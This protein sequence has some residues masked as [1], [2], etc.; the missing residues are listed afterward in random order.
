MELKEIKRSE[1]S[2]IAD[3]FLF[4]DVDSEFVKETLKDDRCRFL[5][6]KKGIE[7]FSVVDYRNHLGIVLSGSI[8]V[9]KPA[10]SRYI[11]SVL[12][13]GSIFGAANLF[14]RESECVTVLTSSATCRIVLLSQKLLED[15]MRHDFEIAQNLIRFLSGRVQFLNDKIQGLVAST[16][17][18]ALAH[19][20]MINANLDKQE[21][22]LVHPRGSISALADELNIGR[23]SLYRAFE[24]LEK[25]GLIK[26]DGREIEILDMEGI[27][28]V[29]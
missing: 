24:A 28:R 19:Y 12:R 1:F 3:C 5:E 8:Q 10:N 21:R 29:R 6:L 25:N 27:S 7:L 18:A 26:K 14:D 23:A 13:R 22:Y 17:N 11:M 20:L 4:E 15:I 16:A 2:I 9:T